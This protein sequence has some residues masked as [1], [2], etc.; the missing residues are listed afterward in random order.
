M[1]RTVYID[2]FKNRKIDREYDRMFTING[3]Y[4]ELQD[5]YA[6]ES[7]NRLLKRSR[8]LSGRGY[9][10]LDIK[11]SRALIKKLGLDLDEALW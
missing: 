10:R 11:A 7:P 2:Y 8:N 9:K 4:L 1:I 3:D 6:C 5:W